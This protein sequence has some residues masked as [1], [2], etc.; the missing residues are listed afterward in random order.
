[1]NFSEQFTGRS[2][3]GRKANRTSNNNTNSTTNVAT[4]TTD[5]SNRPA[6]DR[7]KGQKLRCIWEN[8]S[9]TCR[10]C[11]RARAVCQQPRPRP[12]GRPRCSTKSKHHVAQNQAN[13]KIWVSSTTQQPQENDAEMPMATSDDHDPTSF[14]SS[15]AVD[16]PRYLGLA[17]FPTDPSLQI[18]ISPPHGVHGNSFNLETGLL[19]NFSDAQFKNPATFYQPQGFINAAN[20]AT[21][22]PVPVPASAPVSADGASL[23][24]FDPDDISGDSEHSHCHWLKQL[25][26]LNVAIYQHP[27]HPKPAGVSTPG[28]STGFSAEQVSL[29]SLQIG[30][31]LHMTS[32]LGRLTE[33]IDSADHVQPKN[34]GSAESDSFGGIKLAI[35]DRSTF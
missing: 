31:L 11:T 23:F 4:V 34:D 24:E 12:F 27:L 29:S 17:S 20:P 19:G 3:P 21:P 33:E 26:D 14:L 16:L 7:C 10:R 5:D 2:E 8:G 9:N 28:V 30:R 18:A 22:A 15:T 32:R 1:M 25:G 6:C 13:T 35:N